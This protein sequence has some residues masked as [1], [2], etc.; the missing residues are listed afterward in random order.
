MKVGEIGISAD[1]SDLHL[2]DPGTGQRLAA[3]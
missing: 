2:F 1:L 3:G